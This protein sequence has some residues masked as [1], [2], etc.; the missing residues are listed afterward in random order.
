MDD[1]S[2]GFRENVPAAATLHVHDVREPLDTIARDTGARSI[3]HLAAQADVRVSVA[4]P[5]RDAAINVARH[6]ERPRGRPT[7]RRP[8]RLRL[9]GRSDLRRVRATG[10][11]GRPVPAPLPV[12]GGEAR[13]RGLPR[14]VR[15][16]LRRP[17]RRAALRQRLR[18]PP[19]S[20]RRGG[21]RRD[22]PRP[23]PERGA[24]PDL[25]GRLPEPGLRLRGRRRTSDDRGARQ[26]RRRRVQR[27][28]RH[29]DDRARALRG[30]PLGRRLRRG[31]RATRR[32][33][34]ASSV[35]ACSTASTQPRLSASARTTSL[36]AGVAATWAA[37]PP[38]A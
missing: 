31:R 8:R 23:T 32:N 27:R 18:P 36:A 21:R 16:A 10:P 3:V 2:T 12:R 29:R 19:E 35:G 25:R 17:P 26:R 7:R 5:C 11:R 33:G 13:R 24:V 20:A 38:L 4:E 14:R 1:L 37:L 15:P 30:V 34:R 22:L 6:R 9:D 28:H